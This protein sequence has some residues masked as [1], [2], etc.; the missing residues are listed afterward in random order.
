M[1]MNPYQSPECQNQIKKASN[2]MIS[3]TFEMAVVFGLIV[4]S[5][6]GLVRL[7]QDRGI[8]VERNKVQEFWFFEDLR[9][10]ITDNT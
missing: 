3:L 10:Y 4:L 8:I 1:D 7:M 6:Y 2:Y 9:N 5:T